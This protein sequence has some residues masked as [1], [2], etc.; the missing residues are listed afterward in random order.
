LEKLI[1][2]CEEIGLARE[3]KEF[4][5]AFLERKNLCFYGIT[6]ESDL[7]ELVIRNLTHLLNDI[8]PFD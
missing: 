3:E 1:N 6:A 2:Y 8:P 4:K 7:I 5:R